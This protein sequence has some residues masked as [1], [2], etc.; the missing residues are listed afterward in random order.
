VQLYRNNTRHEAYGT[1]DSMYPLEL[2]YSE[3]FVA[4]SP[5]LAA[6]AFSAINTPAAR[7]CIERRQSH[8]PRE[9][10][11][12]E[13]SKVEEPLYSHFGA[14]PLAAPLHG[15]P[16]Y[17]TRTT[18]LSP[19]GSKERPAK[20]RYYF[21]SFGFVVGPAVVTLNATGAPRPFRTASE[22]RLLQVLYQRARAHEL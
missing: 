9:T 7:A 2:A 18:A 12:R 8:E 10:I 21:D 20:V 11:R 16:V 22:Q 15:V 14:A 4:A 5:A 3:V 1:S 17:A 19:T 13:G 6:K